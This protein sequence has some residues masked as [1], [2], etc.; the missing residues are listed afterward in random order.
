MSLNH[1]ITKDTINR[2]GRRFRVFTFYDDCNDA[3]WERDD[4][5][6]PVSDWRTGYQHEGLKRPCERVL[7]RDRNSYRFYDMQEAL[8][9]A[10]RDGW[11]LGDDEKAKL[12]Q[13]LGRTPTAKQIRAEAVERDF[14]YL[15]GWCNDE[16]HYV[17]VVVMPIDQDEDGEDIEIDDIDYSYALWGV[18]NNDDNYLECVAGEL[19]DQI[20]GDEKMEAQKT[21]LRDRAEATEAAFWANMDLATL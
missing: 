14:Q 19:I 2:D 21:E 12:A 3:P 18:E 13:R 6:G 15:R 11:G 17:G 16:W 7:A 9:I 4:G 5:H 10:K 1:P 8:K 20:L